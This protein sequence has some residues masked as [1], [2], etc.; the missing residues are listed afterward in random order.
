MSFKRNERPNGSRRNS[1]FSQQVNGL[2]LGFDS[3]SMSKAQRTK[4][5]RD[6]ES[7]TKQ[8]KL[9]QSPKLRFS[10]IK[11]TL[12]KIKSTKDEVFSLP[13]SPERHKEKNNYLSIASSKA[14]LFSDLL[15]KRAPSETSNKSNNTK[16]MVEM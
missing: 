14:S 1:V 15:E 12:N 9:Q 6:A 2:R 16:R 11:R 5:K 8:Q 7:I 13:I 10:K 3:L 4:I